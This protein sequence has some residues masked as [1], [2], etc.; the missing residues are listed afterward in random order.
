MLEITRGLVSLGKET[1]VRDTIHVLAQEDDVNPALMYSR[2]SY[3]S[4]HAQL[5]KFQTDLAAHAL[6]QQHREMNRAH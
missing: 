2:S 4:L 3:T 6:A 1:S 5:Q